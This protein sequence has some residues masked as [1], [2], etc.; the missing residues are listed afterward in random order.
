M[1]YRRLLNRKTR[2][3]INVGLETGDDERRLNGRL[4][5]FVIKLVFYKRF[6]SIFMQ[7]HCRNSRFTYVLKLRVVLQ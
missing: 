3:I 6:H 5:Y 2:K 7:V 4:F 1:S